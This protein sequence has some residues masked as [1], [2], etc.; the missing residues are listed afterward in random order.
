M[1]PPELTPEQHLNWLVGIRA[2]RKSTAALAA[3]GVLASTGTAVLGARSLLT[4][5][6]DQVRNVIPK[7]WDVPP[8]ADGIYAP[9]AAAPPSS[10]GNAG[11]SS[12]SI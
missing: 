11:W 8:R 4:G 1:R 5:Q 12:T 3:A 6:A 7:S 9:L 2:P 10:A